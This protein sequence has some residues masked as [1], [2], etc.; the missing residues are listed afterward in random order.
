MGVIYRPPGQN[1]KEFNEEIDELLTGMKNNSKEVILLEDFNID[2]L[3]INGHNDSN[4]FHNC[5]VSH[6]SLP[7]IT[8][9]TRITPDTRTLIDNIF[10]NA[11]SKLIEA[12]IIISDISDHLPIYARFSLQTIPIK[13]SCYKKNRTINED[14][15]NKFKS[16]L[17]DENWDTV[18]RACSSGNANE[19][20]E[21]FFGKY[22]QA[23]NAAFPVVTEGK[24]R[25]VQFKKPWMTSG[26][27][28]SCRKN[29][30]I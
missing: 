17:A 14:N 6:H 26:I 22:S 3:K 21:Q 27:L 2:L 20:Y 10:S 19:A 7:T 5:L 9:P 30:P 11:W 24:D 8:R 4:S 1:L 23:Y 13:N 18:M 16:A 25:K 15:L 28:K 12:S 29:C